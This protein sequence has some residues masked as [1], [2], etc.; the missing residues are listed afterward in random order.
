MVEYIK[1]CDQYPYNFNFDHF[2]SSIILP[3]FCWGKYRFP[4]NAVPVKW[5]TSYS[6]VESFAWE[7]EQKWKDSI[8]WLANV[9]C[10][11]LK[12]VTFPGLPTR[13]WGCQCQKGFV[14]L[15]ELHESKFPGK[16]SWQSTVS[17]PFLCWEAYVLKTWLVG[18]IYKFQK[19]FKKYSGEINFLRVH[20][21]IRGYILAWS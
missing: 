19:N 20:R 18:Y 4:E 13:F 16:H 5:V 15:E 21:N 10:S 14:C 9:C 8:F 2:F 12:F 3:P 11:N 6:L 7:N 1:T 17:F